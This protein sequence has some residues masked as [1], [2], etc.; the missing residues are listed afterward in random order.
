MSIAIGRPVIR[1]T[2]RLFFSGM[3]LA[4][5]LMLFLGFLP[6]YFNRSA[7]VGIEIERAPL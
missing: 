3:A 6:S 4:S 2:D 5:A 7:E 1:N